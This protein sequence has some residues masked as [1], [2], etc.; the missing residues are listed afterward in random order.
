MD[1]RCRAH[2]RK[3]YFYGFRVVLNLSLKY[4]N[5]AIAVLWFPRVLS[6]FYA[7]RRN[8]TMVSYSSAI[9]AGRSSVLCQALCGKPAKPQIITSR[10]FPASFSIGASDEHGRVP[11]LWGHDL[12]ARGRSHRSS[13]VQPTRGSDVQVSE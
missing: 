2:G 7:G 13:A 3:V 5:T 11:H 4:D 10:G 1:L 8:S 12:R 9:T 6:A